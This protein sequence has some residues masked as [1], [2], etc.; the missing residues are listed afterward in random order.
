ME[1]G[2]VSVVFRCRPVQGRQRASAESRE[3]AWLTRAE[4]EQLMPE[5]RAVRVADAFRADGPF[6]RIHDGR[7]VLAPDDACST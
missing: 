4:A 2:V 3:V 7:V 6:V 1:L 5:A